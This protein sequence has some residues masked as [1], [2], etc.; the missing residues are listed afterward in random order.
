MKRE[1]LSTHHHASGTHHFTHHICFLSLNKKKRELK[2]EEKF[3]LI[4]SSSTVSEG[5]RE[6]E[7]KTIKNLEENE[8]EKP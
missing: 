1:T 4:T 2:G 8:S 6:K 3:H 5:E 7:W